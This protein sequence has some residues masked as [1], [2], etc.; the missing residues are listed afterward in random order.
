[1][2]LTDI[3][4]IAADTSRTL[5]YLRELIENDLIPA[6]ILVLLSP[7][8]VLLPGQEIYDSQ[9]QLITM[10]CEANIEYDISTNHDINSEEVISVLSARSEVIFIYSGF[11]GVL[12]REEILSMGK[13]FLHVHGGYLP[14][15]KG[16]TTNYYSLIEENTIGASSI[17]LTEDIDCGPI[18]MRRKFPAPAEREK[19][20]HI[21]DSECRAS[22]LI[23]T[24]AA[25]TR[26]GSFKFDLESN[27]GG[28]TFYVIHPVLKHI[29]ILG[30]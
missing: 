11:G 21:Y 29:A 24:L 20:D 28:Q 18:I 10:L 6:Y 14:N 15:Y 13:D 23:E 1:M 27:I 12:L 17:F 2:R 22:V 5:I 3:G 19:L 25:Y 4:M 8:K 7:G 9:D 26:N 16:S 30:E